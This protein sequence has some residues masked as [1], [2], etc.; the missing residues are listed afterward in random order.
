MNPRCSFAPK[1][2]VTAV[3]SLLVIGWLTCCCQADDF[4]PVFNNEASSEA[5]P[6]PAA[7]AA[8]TMTLPEGFRATVYASEPEVRNPIAMAWD[9]RG[10]MWVAE[11]YTYS[12]RTQH[13]DL[14]LRDRVIIL[15]DRDGDGHAESRKVFTDNVQMLTS[16]EIGRGGVWLMCPPQL[17]FI[18]DAD[19]DDVPDGS[20]EVVLD[21]FTV[22]QSNYHNFANGL[23]WGPDG[24]LYG[25]CGHSCPGNLGVPG[26]P[27]DRRIPIDGGMWRFH[28]QRKTVEVLNHGTVNPWGSDWDANGELFF[29]NTVIGHLWHSIPG[30]HFIESFGESPNPL[31][32]ERMDMIADHYHY[33]RS[34]SWTNSRDGAANDLG[35]GHAHIGMMIYQSDRWPQQYH[36]KLFTLNMHGLRANVET[37]KRHGAGYLAS[38]EPDFLISKDPFFRGIEISVGPDG[39]VYVLDWSDTGECHDHTGV[40]RTS[41][42]VYKISYDAGNKPSHRFSKPACLAGDGELPQL[43]RDYQAG[44]TTPAQLRSLLRDPDEHVRVWAIRLLTDHWP[45]DTFLGPQRDVEYPNDPE[46]LA[47]LKRTA[48]QDPSGLVHLTLASTLQ[49]LPVRERALIASE[50]VAQPR[51]AADRDLPMMVWFGLIPLV[52]QDP[53]AL[54]RVAA[55]CRWPDTLRWITRGLATRVETTPAP[56]DEVLTASLKMPA[57]LQ[58]S[59]LEGMAEAYRGWLKVPMPKTW[60]SIVQ[61]RAAKANPDTVRELNLLFGDGRAI[62]ELRELA[63]SSK[64]TLKTRQSAL[65]SLIGARPDDLR[66]ICESLLDQREL[67]ATAAQGL[68][69]FDDPAVGE[70]LAKMYRRFHINDRPGLIEILVSRPSFA[71]ALLDRIDA[72]RDPIPR[73]DITAFHARQILGLGDDGLREKLTE[74]WGALRESPA[75]R[76]EKI[77]AVKTMLSGDVLAKADLPTGRALFKKT[78]SQCHMLFGDGEKIG[79]DLTGAQRSSLD[80]LLENILDPSAVVGKDHRMTIVLTAD[81]RVLNGLVVSQNDK[82]M[83]IQ[84]QSRQETIPI[85]SIENVKETTLS[86]MPDGLLTTLTEEQIRDLIGYLMHP[87]Q[88]ELE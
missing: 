14:S 6:M 12:D 17:L 63:M 27:D 26:T 59:V 74:S 10:R 44:K 51:F 23:R 15:N 53:A 70:K 22:S 43:W 47:A 19:G 49:R 85:D 5:S 66:E 32:F 86:P 25:R 38:H 16:V 76:R 30:A 58:A 40:H 78:C 69:R 37:I 73:S 33:D 42:R 72:D 29:I 13:F 3:A 8:A 71:A 39:D 65:E 9:D 57:A 80:Y 28:P 45:L 84:T 67:N 31:V 41:G 52:D 62:D 83:V 75:E 54:A 20:P 68:S 55:N 35:G 24:W 34:G 64:V 79:P 7:E 11:N 1:Q 88:V 2:F 4:P 81:G 87:T 48:Q 61:S 21:G 18:P 50:L 46:T 82:T 56:L 60:P 36:N 77:A